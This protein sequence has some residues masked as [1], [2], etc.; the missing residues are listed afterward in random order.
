MK[1]FN[2]G[3][4]VDGDTAHGPN[5]ET[6]LVRLVRVHLRAGDTRRVLDTVN[7]SVAYRCVCDHRH[8]ASYGVGHDYEVAAMAHV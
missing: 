5:G 6:A 8:P 1:E 7:G 3:W 4:T 2:D